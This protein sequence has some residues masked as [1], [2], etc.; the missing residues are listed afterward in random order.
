[1]L[2]Q[3]LM[4]LIDDQL[5]GTLDEMNRGELKANISTL[6]EK[7]K[8]PEVIREHT[9][10]VLAE[11]LNPPVRKQL[12]SSINALFSEPM[13]GRVVTADQHRLVNDRRVR[14]VAEK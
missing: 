4:N 9:L 7:H 13:Q 8:E 1:M 12:E 14:I 10:T 2:L 11:Q 5:D 6:F 3:K